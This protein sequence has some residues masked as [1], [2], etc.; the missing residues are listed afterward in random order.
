MV[1]ADQG[2]NEAHGRRRARQHQDLLVHALR[3]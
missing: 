3:I 2:V 1:G